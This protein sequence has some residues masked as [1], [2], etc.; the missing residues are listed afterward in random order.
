MLHRK[1]LLGAQSADKIQRT[2]SQQYAHPLKGIEPLSK[3]QQRPEQHKHRTRGINRTGDGE[4]QI[5]HRIITHSPRRK[6]YQRLDEDIE[7]PH[8]I[9]AKAYTPFCHC[10]HQNGRHQQRSKQC[11]EKQYR[12]HIITAKRQF[13]KD[14]VYA[15][16]H[17]RHH[18]K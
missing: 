4:R 5:F 11:I 2:K 10:Q 3:N 13:L 17:R 6:H 15:Q 18:C 9:A 16:T 12:K 7:V 1:T 8:R 14:V